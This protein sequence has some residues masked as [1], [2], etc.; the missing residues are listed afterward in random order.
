MWAASNSI[1]MLIKV[2]MGLC[3]WAG[4][5]GMEHSSSNVFV[6]DDAPLVLASLGATLALNGYN[7]FKFD[8]AQRFLSFVSPQ[9]SGCVLVDV[10]MAGMSGLQ[11]QEAIASMNGALAAIVMSGLAD[12]PMAVHALKAGAV[13]FLQKPFKN[14]TLID[15]VQAALEI[16]NRRAATRE[17]VAIIG[18][19]LAQLTNRESEVCRLLVEG[20][21]NK[22]IAWRLSISDRTVEVHR[23]SVMR[24]VGVKNVAALSRMVSVGAHT[25]PAGYPV[26][27]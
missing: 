27:A 22:Q 9:H 23:A 6:V 5:V 26:P 25:W 4:V 8:S 7:V 3:F 14:Q 1:Y 16:A 20:L 11:L 17:S 18:E 13:D 24:K 12:I 21:P 2:N 19:K 10:Q 15:M